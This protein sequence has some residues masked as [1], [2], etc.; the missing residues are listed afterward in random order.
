MTLMAIAESRSEHSLSKAIL[1][2]VRESLSTQ[3]F[4]ICSVQAVPGCGL[5]SNIKLSDEDIANVNIIQDKCE[6]FLDVDDQRP[7]KLVADIEYNVLIGNREWMKRNFL[8]VTEKVEELMQTYEANGDTCVLC[9]I[10]KRIVAMIVLND[11]VKPDAH[12]AVYTLKRMGLEVYLLTGDNRQT[13]LSIANQVGIEHV[14]AQVLPQHKVSKIEEL[15]MSRG[16]VAMVGDGI[17]DLPALAKADIGIAVGT[18]A[19]VAVEAANVVLIRD[20]LIDVIGALEL[21]KATIKRI[22]TNFIFA[23]VYNL[24]GIPIAAGVFLSIGLRLQP[25]MASM[26]MVASSISVVCSSLLLNLHKKPTYKRLC[27]SEYMALPG[28]TSS[29]CRA[30]K[31]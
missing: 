11:K 21:S 16:L 28:C 15:Q 31:Q 24:I 18:G 13:A 23:S 30:N 19:D 26:A 7:S 2:F 27:T 4:K 20:S 5:M 25:W 3:V 6:Y 12:L 9:A 22:K 17:D 29:H 1:K 14:M 10:N 8:T